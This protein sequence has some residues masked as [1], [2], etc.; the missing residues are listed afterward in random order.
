[1]LRYNDDGVH[2]DIIDELPVLSIEVW[3]KDLDD[4]SGCH[5]SLRPC[6][7]EEGLYGW[8]LVY[9]GDN[10]PETLLAIWWKPENKNVEGTI[11]PDWLAEINDSLVELEEIG[12][13]EHDLS[14]ISSFVKEAT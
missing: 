14:W 4:D 10:Y 6:V 11:E 2:W 3:R 9:S 1:M 5:L 7:H 12:L 13:D 8:A